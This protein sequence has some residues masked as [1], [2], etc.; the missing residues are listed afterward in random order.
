MILGPRA[1]AAR[2]SGALPGDC[3]GNAPWQKPRQEWAQDLHPVSPTPNPVIAVS[4]P[5][6]ARCCFNMRAFSLNGPSLPAIY[7]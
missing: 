5:V 7:G 3:A 1:E 4:S 6:P 2:D